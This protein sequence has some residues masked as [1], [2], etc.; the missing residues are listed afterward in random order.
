MALPFINSSA[1]KKRESIIAVDLGGR[2]TKAVHLQK[3]GDQFVLSGCAVM[4]APIYE[5]TL[6]A[7]MLSEHLKAVCQT[8]D[9]RTKL[10][11][12]VISV[13]DSIVRH[14]EMPMMPL[15][16]MRQVLKMNSKNYL[17]QDLPGYVYDCF[18]TPP[19]APSNTASPESKPKMPSSLQKHRVLVGGAKRQMVEDMQQ[20]MKGAGLISDSVMRSLISALSTRPSA[21]CKRAIWP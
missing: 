9:A 15:E 17:Q 3:K 14:T 12:L 18:I 8:L 16:D 5:K 19:K 6:S 11:T 10:A 4:D 7:D 1:P 2:T 21:S 20:A 13:N